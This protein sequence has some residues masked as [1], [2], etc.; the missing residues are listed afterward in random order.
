MEKTF[1][2]KKETERELAHTEVYVDGEYVGYVIKASL[3]EH[4]RVVDVNWHFSTKHPSY[5]CLR[6]RTK[7]ELIENISPKD[8]AVTK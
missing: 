8:L 2:H 7:K 1:K 3:P 4:L 5:S 6:G